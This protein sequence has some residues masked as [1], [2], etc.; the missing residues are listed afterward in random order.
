MISVRREVAARLGTG[1]EPREARAEAIVGVSVGLAPGQDVLVVAV[2]GL[3]MPRGGRGEGLPSNHH[4]DSLNIHDT[5][6]HI[7][8]YFYIAT[9]YLS[10]FSIS[11]LP[12]QCNPS[13]TLNEI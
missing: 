3:V 4:F 2:G 7:N 1:L 8:R 5:Y 10:I 11:T 6:S 9:K 12:C 13:Y